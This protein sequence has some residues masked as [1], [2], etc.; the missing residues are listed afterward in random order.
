MPEVSRQTCGRAAS[1]ASVQ[2]HGCGG[3]PW[4]GWQP[5]P[6]EGVM[7]ALETSSL[8]AGR[9]WRPRQG[10]DTPASAPEVTAA[11]VAFQRPAYPVPRIH[12]EARINHDTQRP[13]PANGTKARPVSAARHPQ[14]GARGTRDRETGPCRFCPPPEHRSRAGLV[15]PVASVAAGASAAGS[16]PGTSPG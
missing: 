4:V 6:E 9:R 5:W 3:S 7:P 14:P 12:H 1:R 15:T 16:G 11:P 13:Y 8:P 10:C 2:Q